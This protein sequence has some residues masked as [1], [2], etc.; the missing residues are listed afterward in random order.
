ME[1]GFTSKV[2]YG[3]H[4]KPNW[5]SLTS[6]AVSWRLEGLPL[7]KRSENRDLLAVDGRQRNT[8]S[9]TEFSYCIFLI[10]LGGTSATNGGLLTVK[11]KSYQRTASVNDKD[12]I[13]RARF[14]PES[15]AFSNTPSSTSW[16]LCLA[17]CSR[18]WDRFHNSWLAIAAALGVGKG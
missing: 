1:Y 9:S 8:T 13:V 2:V 6:E 5:K 14:K 7:S 15:V 10:P 12:E 18:S 3:Q 11:K 17:D 4:C 16:S